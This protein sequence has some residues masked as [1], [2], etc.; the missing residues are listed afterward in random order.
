MAPPRKHDTDDILD[1]ART[2]ALRDG[3]RSTS[4]AAIASESGAPAGSLYHRFGNRDRLLQAAWLRALTR[5][6]HDVLA[7]A[8]EPDPVEAGVAMA[9]AAVGFARRHPED[10][11]LLVVV[12]RDD[13]LDGEPDATF[14]ARLATMNAPLEKQIRRLARALHGR[15]SA[16]ARHAVVAAV[17]DVPGAAVRRHAGA[18]KPMPAWLEDAVAASARRLLAPAFLLE[19]D[20]Q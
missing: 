3:P 16:R 8:S 9:V 12:R 4:V 6:Q 7:A 2:V 10:A 11:L 19:A 18:A 13:L 14:T 5:F 15:A 1:A 20:T 17:V